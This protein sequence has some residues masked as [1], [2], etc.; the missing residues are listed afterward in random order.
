MNKKT[1][2]F[3]I[4]KKHRTKVIVAG[5]L[6]LTPIAYKI[7]K[8]FYKTPAE[9]HFL[10]IPTS[11]DKIKEDKL[12]IE[13]INHKNMDLETV[14]VS[15]EMNYLG[16]HN[17]KGIQ[18]KNK[19][20]DDY[21][22]KNKVLLLN[23]NIMQN[24]V[25]ASFEIHNMC[26]NVVDM[27]ANDTTL[28]EKF[29]IPNHLH[30][31]IRESWTRRDRE[32]VGR[33]E[34]MWNGDNKPKFIDYIINDFNYI[35]EASK[36]QDLIISNFAHIYGVKSLNSLNFIENALGTF[37]RNFKINRS[38]DNVWIIH[39]PYDYKEVSIS[40]FIKNVFSNRNFGSSN[41]PQSLVLKS[42]EFF[43]KNLNSDEIN[44]EKNLFLNINNT[45]L[46]NMN[47]DI[48]F[49]NSNLIEPY[50][51][52]ILQSKALLPFLYQL[53]PN[54]QYLLPAYFESDNI[55]KNN[56]HIKRTF[57]NSNEC[58]YQQKYE[59]VE[60][61]GKTFSFDV[62]VVLGL[63]VGLGVR[64]KKA[65][66]ES[67]ISHFYKNGYKEFNLNLNEKDKELRSSLY[68]DDIDNIL[69][70]YERKAKNFKINPPI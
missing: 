34:F 3:D 2:P 70:I 30:T 45:T 17:S 46:M 28:L 16:Y 35:I 50:W 59:S 36:G 1:S 44:C 7:M 32:M 62:W 21:F 56:F 33:M 29:N 65:N 23:S 20:I 26:L 54:S 66:Q 9:K 64:L 52:L 22:Y 12:G 67:F 55:D 10:N 48:V 43:N 38:Y 39:N 41:Q 69:K 42:N 4:V 58:I 61:K 31:Q 14:D 47:T 49:K 24:L 13:I 18:W 27:V 68:G 40:K 60:I 5:A 57:N 15:L 19:M 25:E 63:P 51:K 11:E 8:I 37:W 53:Y 6:I